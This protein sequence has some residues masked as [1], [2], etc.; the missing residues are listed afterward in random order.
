MTTVSQT[1]TGRI[2]PDWLQNA[3]GLGWRILAAIVLGAL[4][5]F[6]AGRLATVTVSV[7]VAVIIASTFA[8]FVL[9]LRRR[10]WSRTRSAGVVT[11]AAVLIVG[12]TV[13]LISLA[14]VPYIPA[15]VTSID[16]GIA[17]LETY[18]A[19]VSVPP[20]V[21]TTAAAVMKALEVWLSQS[22]ASIASALA[23]IAGVA[24]LALFTLFFL[25]QD[26]DKAWVWAFQDVKGPRRARIMDAGNDA[27]DRVGGYLRGTAI[28]AASDALSDFVFLYL[29]GVPLAAPLAVLVFFGGFIPYFGGIVTTTLMVIVTLATNGPQDVLIL[30]VLITIVNVIQGNVLAPIIYGKTVN[31]H[32]AVVLLALPAGAAVAGIVGL[33]VAIP[34]VAIVMAVT[35]AI[36]M[37]LDPGPDHP[38][39][40]LVPGWL[41]RLAQWSWRLVLVTAVLAVVIE[42]IV[43]VPMVTIPVVLA[44]ILAATLDPLMK[45]LVARGWRRSVAA[46]ASTGGAFLI[47]LA[48]VVVT[49]ASLIGQADQIT[50]TATEGAA[51]IDQA[52]GGFLGWLAATVQA[53]GTGVVVA[54]AGIAAGIATLFVI[55][56]LSGLLCF[57]MLKDGPQF[58]RQLLARL[59]PGRD[60]EV[61]SAGSQAIG[62]LG[63]YMV[64]TSAISAFGAA[65]QYVVMILLGLPLAL[66]LAVLSF[67]G[68][69]IPYIGSIITTGLAFLVTV[70]VGS[71]QQIAIMAIFTLVLNI[72]QG[73]FVAPLVYSRAVNL[74]PAIVLLAIPAGSEIAGVIGMF[75]AVP[76]LGVISATWRSVLRVFATEPP[77]PVEEPDGHR[78]DA[79]PE[80]LE[81]VPPATGPTPDASPS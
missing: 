78:T 63:G 17:E 5:F 74:H 72:V 23:S 10:G 71:P 36:V 77:M 75:L 56:I 70:A 29:L 59:P 79:P 12:T 50:G 80:P 9:R 15:L 61:D 64:G 60:R 65:T 40:T 55:L 41:D 16:Q 46:V 22:L 62:V 81:P 69:F 51:T 39:P 34:V 7:L 37:I 31:M 76:F 20:E 57:Y 1:P 19:E 30:L 49:V 52:S 58:E 6:V 3:A 18:L 68:G 28:L 4:I 27:L 66:P 43:Q 47:V 2:V 21:A 54:L 73:N 38:G 67:F 42:I 25:L 13:V 45:R 48:I 24:L 32:P 14:F 44:V 33:F 8:P 11:I 26:G 53:Y 35:G